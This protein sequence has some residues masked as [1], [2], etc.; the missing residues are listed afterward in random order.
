MPGTGGRRKACEEALRY[1][2]EAVDKD[3]NFALAH[4][5][6]ADTYHLIGPSA[7]IPDAP[8]RARAA[9]ERASQL[10]ETLA[11]AHTSLARLLH[12]IAGDIDRADVEF[13]RAIELNPGY[14]TA[15]QW[16]GTLLAETGRHKEAQDHGERA[17]ALDPLSAAIRQS[18]ALVYF[19]GRQYERAAAEATSGPGHHT[20]AAPRATGSG[21]SLLEIG[22]RAGR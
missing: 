22:S 7:G 8:A 6:L 16:Y 1:F 4:A 3:P 20:G 2:Q 18:L 9:A 21:P 12:R 10:D 14:A 15:H 13:R 11:E 17:V 5:G 19:V